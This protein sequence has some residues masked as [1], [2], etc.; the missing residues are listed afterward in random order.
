M[1]KTPNTEKRPLKTEPKLKVD[2]NEE[3]K[4]FVKLFYEY[5]VNFLLGDFGSGKSLAAV[6]TAL[7][8]FR[9]KQFDN[10][11]ITR[12]MIKNNLGALPGELEDKLS[13]YIFPIPELLVQSF[14]PFL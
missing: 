4:E 12:P 14:H 13:P 7:S 11:W 5:D 2:L 6:H 10:I 3:Q 8:S 9:K 1:A